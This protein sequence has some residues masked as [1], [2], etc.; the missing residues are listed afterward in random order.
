MFA[1]GGRLVEDMRMELPFPRD[2][3]SDQV[4]L[5]RAN[6]LRKFESLDLVAT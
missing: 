2:G 5:A 3:G 1:K 6:L 4:A